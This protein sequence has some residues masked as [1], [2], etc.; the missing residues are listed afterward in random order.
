MFNKTRIIN[1]TTN[2]D[3][4][5]D[6]A[7]TTSIDKQRLKVVQVVMLLI[8]YHYCEIWR[9]MFALSVGIPKLTVK[10]YSIYHVACVLFPIYDI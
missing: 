10:V 1:T 6:N 3:I 7:N 2:S 5:V 8:Y 4:Q 9:L